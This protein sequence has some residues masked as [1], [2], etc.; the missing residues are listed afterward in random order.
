MFHFGWFGH[1][2]GPIMGSVLCDLFLNSWPL[3][4][5]HPM[6][7]CAEGCSFSYIPKSE[8]IYV[9]IPT[10][11]RGYPNI[12]GGYSNI[13]GGYSNK[14]S[15]FKTIFCTNWHAMTRKYARKPRFAHQND[16]FLELLRFFLLPNLY[17][18]PQGGTLVQRDWVTSRVRFGRGWTFRPK[19]VKFWLPLVKGFR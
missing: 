10:K 1:L 5:P 6:H 14:T 4:W 12:G 8:D 15:E 11:T 7:P 13:G 19:Y 18:H 2:V 9:L 16:L 3:K 17:I